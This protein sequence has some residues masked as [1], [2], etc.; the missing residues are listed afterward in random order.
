[1]KNNTKFPIFYFLGAFAVITVGIFFSLKFGSQ[2][3]SVPKIKLSYFVDEFELAQAIHK[4]LNLEF[5]QAQVYV[6][7]VEPNHDEHVQ[8]WQNFLKI[9]QTQPDL[10]VKNFIIEK[11]LFESLS[12]ERKQFLSQFKIVDLKSELNQMLD[13][14]N[15]QSLKNMKT[16][17]LVPNVY[18]FKI[19]ESSPFKKIN[20]LQLE[21]NMIHLSASF[22]PEQPEDLAK[23][24]FPCKS[25]ESD[26]EGTAKL[27]CIIQNKAATVR[28][29]I[30]ANQKMIGLMDLIGQNDYLVMIK[31]R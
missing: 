4:R 10:Q 20:N 9:S 31:K 13:F 23:M 28:R 15:E 18:S 12:E 19:L 1:M 11:A 25:Q 30:K 17:I 5:R 7:G 14:L 21:K 26:V 6:L 2:T 3:K 8:L 27:G 24:M 29:K 16:M 22:F